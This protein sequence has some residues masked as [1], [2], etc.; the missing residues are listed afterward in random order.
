MLASC[1][2]YYLTLKMEA[3][4]KCQAASELCSI[5]T[6]NIVLSVIFGIGFVLPLFL[7][8]PLSH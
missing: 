4:P 8:S 2:A 5:T 6:K 7:S 3:L 1:L